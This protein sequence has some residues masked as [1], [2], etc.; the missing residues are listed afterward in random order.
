M[1][2][3]AI[4]G[5]VCAL[6][7]GLALYRK[8]A[9][10]KDMTRIAQ[11]LVDSFKVISQVTVESTKSSGALA[12]AS[13]KQITAVHQTAEDVQQSY[14]ML[15]TIVARAETT[16]GSARTAKDRS[17]RN[18]AEIDHLKSSFVKLRHSSDKLR[19]IAAASLEI[20]EKSAIIHDIAFQT[21]ILSFNA[22]V[23]AERAGENGRGFSV[24]AKE[25]KNLA[26]TSSAAATSIDGIMKQN[27]ELID[28][29]VAEIS[30]L[31]ASNTESFESLHRSFSE[32]VE[33]VVE[34]S[35]NVD[36]IADACMLL[37]SGLNN[38]RQLAESVEA[39]AVRNGE[40]AAGGVGLQQ[41]L[42]AEVEQ[43]N[44]IV[45]DIIGAVTG[46][47]IEDIE[48][49]VAVKR[50][51]DF[52]TID[53]RRLDER[54]DELG[55]VEGTMHIALNDKFEDR[56]LELDKSRRY[57]FI[58]RSGGRSARACRLAQAAGFKRVYNLRGGMLAWHEKHLPATGQ[59]V[60]ESVAA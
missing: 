28:H 25:I 27:S 19:Q 22:A 37:R 47:K 11:Q 56:I 6:L 32:V 8:I 51:D 35:T 60:K 48:P 15:D 4:A 40:N 31:I 14:T 23:E 39:T 21:K 2:L 16:S 41:K 3:L 55:H 18:L 5:W 49:E 44:R 58:C 54:T 9:H 46:A 53:V 50:L 52:I 17:E 26:N 7:L 13:E 20:R 29:S 57:L 12:D 10:F 36:A 33:S 59:S 1:L 24:V 43:L 30:E 45:S 38:I 34:A 42:Q